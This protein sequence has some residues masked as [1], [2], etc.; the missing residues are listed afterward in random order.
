[1]ASVLLN[2]LGIPT[3]LLLDREGRELGRFTGPAA[4][5]SDAVVT[6]IEE[7]LRHAPSAGTSSAET[8]AE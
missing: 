3:T 5:D 1:M 4:W 2:A 8:S 6:V 7:Y